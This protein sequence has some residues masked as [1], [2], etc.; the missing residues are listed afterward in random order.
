MSVKVKLEE[1]I[2]ALEFRVEEMSIFVNKK[3]GKI[4]SVL[5]DEFQEAEDSEN[6]DEEV[7]NE[8]KD[9]LENG[10][11]Y[12]ALP[13]KYE[14]NEYEMIEQFC[15]TLEDEKNKTNLQREIQGRGSFGRFKR[16]IK[17]IGIEE[18]WYR[19]KDEKY[20]EIVIEWC[21]ENDLEYI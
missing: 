13:L 8:A 19:F 15:E 3:T 21:N 14:I 16:M 18:D 5:D 10:E 20:K 4:I 9:I 17:E 6:F 12:I 1:L 11:D 7:V 2:D